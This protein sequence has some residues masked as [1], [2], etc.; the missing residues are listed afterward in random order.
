MKGRLI[1]NGVLS[2]IATICVIA[3]VAIAIAAAGSA[4]HTETDP[5]GRTIRSYNGNGDKVVVAGWLWILSGFATIAAFVMGIV[6][7][8]MQK[9][10]NVRG[11]TITSGVLG[12]LT[13]IPFIG[14]AAVIVSFIGAY[15]IGDAK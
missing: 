15:K 6:T 14:I 11:L 10:Q 8:A 12:I 2:L 5:W 7:L 9:H 13:W 3:V 4:Q 1:T